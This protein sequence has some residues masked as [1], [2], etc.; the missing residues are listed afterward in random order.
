MPNFIF[1]Y[2]Y[3]I[4]KQRKKYEKENKRKATKVIPLGRCVQS[5]YAKRNIEKLHYKI[6]EKKI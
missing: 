2:I 5:A 1:P 3:D 6:S 4:L